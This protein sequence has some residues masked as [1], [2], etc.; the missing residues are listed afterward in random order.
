MITGSAENVEDGKGPEWTGSV[1]VQWFLV[2]WGGW[3]SED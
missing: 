1:R 3:T 2:A